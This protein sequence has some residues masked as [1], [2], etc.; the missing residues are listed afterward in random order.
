MEPT[1]KSE[2]TKK[3]HDPLYVDVRLD[4]DYT[5]D[6]KH[7]VLDV[8]PKEPPVTGLSAV[9][10]QASFGL[11]KSER[12][13][14]VVLLVLVALCLAGAGTVMFRTFGAPI[15]LRHPVPDTLPGA[16]LPPYTSASVVE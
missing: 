8:S 6:T 11:L 4:A 16:D 3:A 7:G 2:A 14:Q 5:K 1:S 13:A 15:A 9:V 10:L 12:A